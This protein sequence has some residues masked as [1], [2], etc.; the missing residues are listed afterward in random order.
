MLCDYLGYDYKK[1]YNGSIRGTNMELGRLFFDRGIFG[2]NP[3]E[4]KIFIKLA[5]NW[6][7]RDAVDF[8]NEYEATKWR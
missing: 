2:D 6:G 5:A 7:N 8:L 4:S 3:D 1:V